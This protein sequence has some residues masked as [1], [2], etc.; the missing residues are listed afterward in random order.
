MLVLTPK[1]GQTVMVEIR[2]PRT[3]R[4]ETRFGVSFGVE[5]RR[6]TNPNASPRHQLKF[7]LS[8][9]DHVECTVLTKGQSVGQYVNQQGRA[10][11]DSGVAIGLDGPGRRPPA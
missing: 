3:G 9:C 7:D 4:I 8:D 5:N 10:L 2:N 6:R 1:A 11:S